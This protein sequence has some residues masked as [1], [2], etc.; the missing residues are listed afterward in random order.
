MPA[1]AEWQPFPGSWEE[2]VK[3]SPVL[4]DLR[5]SGQDV[6]Y[7]LEGESRDASLLTGDAGCDV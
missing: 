3:P 5:L 4:H 2:A 7:V 1:T 6:R